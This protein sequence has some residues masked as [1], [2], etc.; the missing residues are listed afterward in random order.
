MIAPGD[1]T[2]ST[3]LPRGGSEHAAPRGSLAGIRPAGAGD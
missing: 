1:A 2:A 3:S